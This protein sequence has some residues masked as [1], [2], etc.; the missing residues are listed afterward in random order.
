[1]ERKFLEEL[2]LE[3]EAIDKVMLEHGKTVNDTKKK[4]DKVDGL[5]SQITDL[6]G[7]LKDRDTQLEDLK[8]VDAKA[9]QKTID[10]LQESNKNKDTEYQEKLDKQAKEF[11]I[12]SALRDAKALNTKAVKAL[13]DT[14]SIKLDGETLLGLD[15]QLKT[16]QESDA[17]LFKQ[18]QK[19][20]SPTIVAPGN[21]NGGGSGALTKEQ[22]MKEPDDI[23]RQ[24]LIQENRQLFQ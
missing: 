19:P 17:Y 8:K 7:Q 22:I 5:E 15:D 12:E 4:A 1:M 2:G 11:A 14:D 3:K 9:L 10:E 16:L 6:T 18:D 21:P 23:K 20:N 13:L 24:K